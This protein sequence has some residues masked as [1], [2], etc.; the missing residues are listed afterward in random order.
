MPLVVEVHTQLKYSR[1]IIFVITIITI[2]SME[3]SV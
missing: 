2:R 1:I 3:S